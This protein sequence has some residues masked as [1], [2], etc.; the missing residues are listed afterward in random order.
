[1]RRLPFQCEHCKRRFRACCKYCHPEKGRWS[2]FRER[3]GNSER[4]A[5][6][7]SLSLARHAA[8]ELNLK[9]PRGPLHYAGPASGNF[10]QLGSQLGGL[11]DHEPIEDGL[12]E[13]QREPARAVVCGR[14]LRVRILRRA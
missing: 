2:V 11:L 3:S 10:T 1:M 4:V 13:S 14:G 7:S 9:D 6:F 12:E 5:Y 8:A